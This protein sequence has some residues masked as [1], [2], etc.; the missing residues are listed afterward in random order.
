MFK[1]ILKKSLI[2]SLILFSMNA[3]SELSKEFLAN[4]CYQLSHVLVSTSEKQHRQQCIDK[5]HMASMQVNTAAALIMEDEPNSAKG[6]LNNAVAD[7]QYAELLS[8]N[9]YIQIVHSKFE[10][11]KIKT[12]L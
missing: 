4:Q 1:M 2:C 8:C 7:L 12:L 11:Q 5:L 9:Q 6:M 10:A 3:Q